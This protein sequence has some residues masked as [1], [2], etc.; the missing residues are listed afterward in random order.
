M[1]ARYRKMP[2]GLQKLIDLV[3]ARLGKK[4]KDLLCII[5]KEDPEWGSIVRR[6]IL[7][8]DR[9]IMWDQDALNVVLPL[10]PGRILAIALQHCNEKVIDKAKTA[11]KGGQRLDFDEFLE[12]P[13]CNDTDIC[14]ARS[15]LIQRTREAIRSGMVKL[16]EVDPSLEYK[17]AA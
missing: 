7:T 13:D 2:D 10:L 8:I 15:L 5:A 9:L 11:L 17:Q 4:Q 6:K 14:S 16:S 12:T 3:E 1:L